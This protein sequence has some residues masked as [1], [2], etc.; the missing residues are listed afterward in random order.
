MT[1]DLVKS[2]IAGI[3]TNDTI[4]KIRQEG[5][6][7]AEKKRLELA[8]AITR[9]I[10]NDALRDMQARKKIFDETKNKGENQE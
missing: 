4:E 8:G 10:V 3:S 9:L 2:L 5:E 6:E 1:S 7:K